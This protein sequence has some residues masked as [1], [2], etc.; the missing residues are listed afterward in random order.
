MKSVQVHVISQAREAILERREAA[1]GEAIMNVIAIAIGQHVPIAQSCGAILEKGNY[2]WE[3][4]FK[5][6]RSLII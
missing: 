5:F 6:I 4:K 1:I 2:I 3:I